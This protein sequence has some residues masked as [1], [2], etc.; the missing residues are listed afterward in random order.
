MKNI[1]KWFKIKMFKGKRRIM[2]LSHILQQYLFFAKMLLAN[3]WFIYAFFF[4]YK[5]KIMIMCCIDCF[6]RSLALSRL[7]KLIY[8]S[9][10]IFC[11]SRW[12]RLKKKVSMYLPSRLIPNLRHFW[13]RQYWHLF[14]FTRST[15]H[16]LLRGHW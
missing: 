12:T 1:S 8:C 9:W 5:L 15:T 10:R 2:V 4:F 7:S 13:S 6:T 14:L 11:I 16:C 3:V